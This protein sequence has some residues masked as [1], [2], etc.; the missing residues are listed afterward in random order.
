M[1]SYQMFFSTCDEKKNGRLD[2]TSG[3]KITPEFDRNWLICVLVPAKVRLIK[4]HLYL[5]NLRKCIY[6]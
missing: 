4:M 1:V 5:T 3:L 6:I 2:D